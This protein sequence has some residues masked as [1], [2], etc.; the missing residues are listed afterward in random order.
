MHNRINFYLLN[1]KNLNHTY[2]YNPYTF[3]ADCEEINSNLCIWVKH[4]FYL[5]MLEY[6]SDKYE[7]GSFILRGD[8][9]SKITKNGDFQTKSYTDLNKILDFL[10]TE[11]KYTEK[12]LI[13]KK[14]FS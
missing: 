6:L 14:V 13:T 4:Y 12:F 10:I 1:N 11:E 2:Y 5:M 7:Q 3:R 9:T 8:R